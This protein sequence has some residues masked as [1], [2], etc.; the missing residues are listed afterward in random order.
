VAAVFYLISVTTTTVAARSH[1]GKM[2]REIR[3]QMM[4]LLPQACSSKKRESDDA[5]RSVALLRDQMLHVFRVTTDVRERCVDVVLFFDTLLQLNDRLT[6]TDTPSS[7][8]GIYSTAQRSL[9]QSI[10]NASEFCLDDVP[11]KRWSI[12]SKPSPPLSS[13]P[14]SSSSSL[15]SLATPT[16]PTTAAG[17]IPKSREGYFRNFTVISH[18]SGEALTPFSSALATQLRAAILTSPP[19]FV[20]DSL[21]TF[22]LAM[23]DWRSCFSHP[24]LVDDEKYSSVARCI[25]QHAALELCDLC[26]AVAFEASSPWFLQQRAAQCLALLSD[27]S[28]STPLDVAAAAT[29]TTQLTTTTTTTTTSTTATLTSLTRSLSSDAAQQQKRTSV[30]VDSDGTSTTATATADYRCFVHCVDAIVPR[31]RLLAALHQGGGSGGGG[32]GSSGSTSIFA[33]SSSSSSSLSNAASS[34]SSSS[35]SFA[36]QSSSMTS[37]GA[38]G[39]AASNASSASTGG[40]G[41]PANPLALSSS[42]VDAGN[43]FKTVFTITVMIL[44]NVDLRCRSRWHS[45]CD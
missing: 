39:A 30:A 38:G 13:S 10:C 35:S 36:S 24:T 18:S 8:S 25:V 43:A 6:G 12:E 21:F 45:R 7:V 29:T 33:A 23:P 4:L 44:L 31:L 32:G 9:L 28:A 37:A 20:I 42:S 5:C 16:T 17:A 15:H 11:L 26:I 41:A 1:S 22:L 2:W 14:S 19:F 3:Q 34:S 40:G 27:P